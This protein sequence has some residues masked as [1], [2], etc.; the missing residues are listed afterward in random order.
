MAV[1][2][3][4]AAAL[5]AALLVSDQEESARPVTEIRRNDYGK[6]SVTRTLKIIIDGKEQKAPMEVEVE[7][8]RYTQEQIEEVFQ[9]AVQKLEPLILG[10]NRSLDEVRTDLNLVTEI[11]GEPIEVSWEL[12]RYDLINIYGELNEKGTAEKP[13]GA[14]VNL[15]AYLTYTE[16]ESMQALEEMSVRVY[17]P[18]LSGEE[19]RRARVLQAIEE[20]EEQSREKDVLKL[21][22]EIEG[23]KIILRNPDNPRGWYVLALGPV[24]CLLLAGLQRQNEQKERE[25]RERQMMLDYPEIMNK[26]TLLLGAGMT[27]KKAWEKI[28]QDYERQ[29]EGAG[30]RYAY[31]EMAVAY[32]E[33]QSGVTEAE[34]YERFGKRCGLKA[35]RKLAS[36]LDQN[37]RKGTKGLAALLGAESLQAFEERKAAAK[38]RGEEAGTKLLLPMFFMLAMVLVIV[39]IPA[40]L[41]IQM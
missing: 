19:S 8:K 24:I 18:K 12:N 1:I 16:D 17:P 37:L 3:V 23:R 30:L 20:E 41:S 5:A 2:L 34:S 15:K 14:L 28:V 7:E 38:R 22:N 21:P 40:F 36:L 6:G 39:I 11:P 26:L 33:M 9:K 31:E 29:K 13:E 35:Y 10:G 4:A 25:D 27:V 32:R